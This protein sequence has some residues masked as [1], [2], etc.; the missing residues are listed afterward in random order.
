MKLWQRLLF[1]Y[2]LV[3]GLVGW[4]VLDLVF[5]QVKPLVRQAAEE[6]LVD[7][8][9]L[10][11]EVVATDAQDGRLVITEDLRRAL[12]HYAG[13]ELDAQI[14]GMTKTRT[15][16]HIYITDKNGTV[17]FDSQG[18]HEGENFSQWNDVYLTL[19][20][21][22]GARTTRLRAQ[23]DTSSVLYVAAPV[24]REGMLLG[25]I[26]LGLPGS[27]VAPFVQRAEHRLQ[28]YGSLLLLFCLL[29]GAVLAWRLRYKLGLLQRYAQAVAQDARPAPLVFRNKDEIHALA[30]AVSAMRRKL[31]D[32]TRLEDSITLLTHEMKSPLAAI[33]GAAEIL[34]DQLADAD[35]HTFSDNI[36]HES[37]RLSALLDR[38]LAMAKL[39]KLESLPAERVEV[40]LSDSVNAWQ[41]SRLALLNEK[42]LSVAFDDA[43]IRVEK[44]TFNLA[45]NNLLDNALR[46]AISGSVLRV[47]G[48]ANGVCVENQGPHIP[49]YALPRVCE[50]FYSLSPQTLHQ[51]AMN[52]AQENGQDNREHER[53]K[54][55]GLGLAMVAEIAALH[56]GSVEVKNTAQGVRVCL[57]IEST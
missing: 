37:Q 33:R 10:L 52:H 56:G 1:G 18:K 15:H 22:Y 14:W 13:R 46:F 26:S 34:Q 45:L 36:I 25:V 57:H 3:L 6:T 30:E 21:E 54:S 51:D 2:C 11:A 24:R 20:G 7:A 39:E 43:V 49:D 9:N 12:Q 42:A 8:A 16:T 4:F 53:E 55:S 23:D 28:L 47:E 48:S 40:S 50:R 19:Q 32:R 44:D 38:L 17:L 29:L 35:R 31:E 5:M 27:A 41:S